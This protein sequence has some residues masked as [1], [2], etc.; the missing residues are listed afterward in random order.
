APD[1][2]LQRGDIIFWRDHVGMM[3]DEDTLIHAN[4]NAMAVTYEPL[5][6][7]ILRIRTVEASEVTSRRRIAGLSV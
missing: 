7:A 3:V 5:A 2:P 4:G 1:A 6:N